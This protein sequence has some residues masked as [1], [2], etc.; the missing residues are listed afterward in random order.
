MSE[1]A[2]NLLVRPS[3]HSPSATGKGRGGGKSKGNGGGKS[4]GSN[5][6]FVGAGGVII[7]KCCATSRKTSTR[8]YAVDTGKKSTGRHWDQAEYEAERR[9]LNP[10]RDFKST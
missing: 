4:I 9:K 6:N 7:P 10:D 1:A 8:T 2:F 5:D 3:S